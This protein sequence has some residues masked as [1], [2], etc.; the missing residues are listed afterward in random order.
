VEIAGTGPLPD[1]QVLAA[2][3]EQNLGY[4][5]TLEVRS[6]TEEIQYYPQMLQ[7]PV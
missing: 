2:N 5:V 3:L 6:L 1:I 4:D 7:T